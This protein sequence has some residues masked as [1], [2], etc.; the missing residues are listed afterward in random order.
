M[1]ILKN[2]QKSLAIFLGGAAAGT[3]ITLINRWYALILLLLVAALL[4]GWPLLRSRT[5]KAKES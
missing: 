2:I 5:R 3:L 1:N 4:L